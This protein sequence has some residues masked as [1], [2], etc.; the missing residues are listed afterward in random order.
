MKQ[1][2][3]KVIVGTLVSMVT[4]T[5][6]VVTFLTIFSFGIWYMPE[7][8]MNKCFGDPALTCDTTMMIIDEDDPL[9]LH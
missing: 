9:R 2:I 6:A 7:P 4:A 5:V 1:F 8:K 3:L